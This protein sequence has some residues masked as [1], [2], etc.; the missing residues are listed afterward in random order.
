MSACGCSVDGLRPV[1]QAI[2]ELLARVPG[3]PEVEQ[4][5]LADALGRVL[6][7]PLRAPFAV[8]QWD[9][10]A[11]DGYALRAADL[12]AQGGSLPLCGRIAAGDAASACRELVAA[13]LAGGGQDNVTVV[14]GRMLPG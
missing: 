10:S 4:V 9:N 5:A 12:P 11:M 1:D 13:A 7:E 14:V 8:P 2:G 6:A 3:V